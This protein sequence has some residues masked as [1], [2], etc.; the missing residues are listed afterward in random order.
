MNIIEEL[1]NKPFWVID[2]LPEQVPEGGDGQ[3]FFIEKYLLQPQQRTELQQTFFRILLKLNCYYDIEVYAEKHAVKKKN[4][5]PEELEKVM[6]EQE[7]TLDIL[8][9][10]VPALIVVRPDDLYMTLFNPDEELLGRITQLVSANGLYIRKPEN[11]DFGSDAYIGA[12]GC[13]GGWVA[14]VLQD[15]KLNLKRFETLQGIAQEYPTFKEFLIDM[16]IG[17]PETKEEVRPEAEAR[18]LLGA[19]SSTVFSVP[20]R[21]AV[22]AETEEEQKA[23]NQ[24]VLGKSLSMQTIGILPKIRELDEFLGLRPEYNNV[25]CESHPE[26][27]FARL[28]GSVLMSRKKE[29][30][31]FGDRCETLMNYLDP[32][33]LRGIGNK[34]RE[35]ECNPDDVLD[36]VCLAV[37]ASLKA[38]DLCET[39]P[40][41]PQVDAN[42]L[43]MQIIIPKEQN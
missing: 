37:V 6:M 42:G 18:K 8:L 10:S 40:K 14:A 30:V 19:R 17:L 4:P 35:L 38:Q 5:A 9:P 2:I 23:V 13:K 20:C 34:A 26:L 22:F 1:L 27:C 11:R 43:L 39:V 25:I 41:E 28:R 7:E 32:E 33:V 21:Q 24:N 16:P 31:G 29:L 3:F 36:A 15:G 12:D